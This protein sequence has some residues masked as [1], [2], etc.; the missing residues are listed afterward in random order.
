MMSMI[1]FSRSLSFRASAQFSTSCFMN[2]FASQCSIGYVPGGIFNAE[3][4]RGGKS[5]ARADL[6]SLFVSPARLLNES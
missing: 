6:I 1:Q 2:A 4:L 3:R 5:E